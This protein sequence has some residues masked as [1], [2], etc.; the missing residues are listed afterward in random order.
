MTALRGRQVGSWWHL[1]RRFVEVAT[2]RRLTELEC[3]TVTSWMRSDA[4]AVL[5]R[6]QPVADQRHSLRAASRIQHLAPERTDLIRA[7]LFHDV[8]KQWAGFGIFRRSVA[9][10]L[11]KLGRPLHGRYKTYVEHGPIAAVELERLGCESVV[12]EF[13]RFHHD[14]RPASIDAND[15]SLLEQ[16]DEP[17]KPPGNRSPAIR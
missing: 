17:G 11:T 6:S 13:A 15:W 7:A 3:A 16:A 5:F 8:G 12:I 2:A 10:A 14:G 9:G 1:A 4:E